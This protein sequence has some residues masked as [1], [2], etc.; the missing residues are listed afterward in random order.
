MPSYFYR[1]RDTLGRAHEGIE[2]ASSEDEVLR[3]LSQMQLTPVLIEARGQA[4]GSA[5]K[6]RPAGAVAA[7]SAPRSWAQRLLPHSVQQGAVALF[8]RQLSTMMSAGLPLVRALH[9]IA[10]DQTDARLGRMLGQVGND[11]QKGDSLATALSRHPEAFG[12]VFVSLVQTGEVSGTLDEVLEHTAGYLE[13][14]ELLRLK[15]QAALRYPTF[16]LSFAGAVLAAMFFKIVPMFSEIYARFRVQL[17]APTRLL[18]GISDALTSNALFVGLL[19]AAVVTML[20][21]WLR[22]EAGRV[23]FDTLKFQLP[24]F[25]PLIRM[26]AMTRYART[27]GILLGSGTNILYALRVVR[28]IA[29]NQM[30]GRAIDSVRT[31]V[32]GGSSLS[33][34]MAETGA[35][36]DMLVQMTATGEETGRLDEMLSRTA[37]FYEQRVNAKVEGLSSLVEPVAIVLLGLVIALMLVALYLPIF[38]LGHAMRSGMLGS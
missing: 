29:G 38:N 27:L 35:F 14:A 22:T 16:I 26:Y 13:R 21:M 30:V 11:V 18:L 24:L 36:P 8:A 37:D 28:P 25:G 9:S 15:V 23:Q 2:V 3:A 1:A 31:Q 20:T 12:D 33:R 6:V 34:A 19:I 4:A 17:P 5:A 10:R 7:P 32:E